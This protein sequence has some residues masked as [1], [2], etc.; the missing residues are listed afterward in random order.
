[1][2]SEKKPE[3]LLLPLPIAGHMTSML[4]MAKHLLDPVAGEN[5]S[6]FSITVLVM[7]VFG[8]SSREISSYV[9]Y[10]TVSGLDIG[11]EFLPEVDPPPNAADLRAGVV[12]SIHVDSYKTHVEDSIAKRLKSGRS[13]AGIVVD[14]FAAPIIDVAN[15]LNVPSYVFCTTG[16]A[17]AGLMIYVGID[18]TIDANFLVDRIED[19]ADYVDGFDIPGLANPVPP[20]SMPDPFMDKNDLV[21][22]WFASHGRRFQKTRGI[23]VN[24]FYDFEPC[25]L[26]ALKHDNRF[27]LQNPPVYPIGP[28]FHQTNGKKNHNHQCIKWL[29]K[30]PPSSVVFLCF[31]SNGSFSTEQLAE[32]ATVLD[33]AGHRFLWSVRSRSNAKF[34]YMEDT[35]K[36]KVFSSNFLERTKDRGLVWPSWVPQ[37]EI[38]SHPATAMFVTHCGWNSCL[39]S[40]SLGVPMLAW[41]LY[42]EQHLNA[43]QI[44]EE[45]K[46]GIKL[47]V[48][49]RNGNW[50]TDN[51]L[52]RGIHC[53]MDEGC[54]KGRQVRENVQEM[55]EKAKRTLEKNGSSLLSLQLFKEQLIH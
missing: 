7:N 23:L 39:E 13:V 26:R 6:P 45:I 5:T 42:A 52:E 2:G 32:I 21:F 48:D 14:F 24:T 4:E 3:L 47:T 35:D 15:E 27:L 28:L 1:M 36:E 40:V 34:G 16:A 31:G 29:D 51:E 44:T 20:M 54:Q 10:T 11:F 46:V 43:F 18:K 41:P 9:E 53:L 55:K 30:Q 25:S 19:V 38:L 49:R 37:T 22:D 8:S 17:M 12:L 50:V 33:R